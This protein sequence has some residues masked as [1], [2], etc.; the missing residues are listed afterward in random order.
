MATGTST[1]DGLGMGLQGEYE[2][3]QQVS[4]T[5][6]F[7]ITGAA[8]DGAGTLLTIQ[9]S[10]KAPAVNGFRIFDYGRTR[11]IRTDDAA[12]GGAFKNALDVKYDLN[13]AAGASQ[14]Y[15]A[16]FILDTAGG[17]W[18]GGRFSVI[19]L[20]SYGDSGVS[21]GNAASWIHLNDLGTTEVKTFLHVLG[22][23]IDTGIMESITDASTTHGLVMYWQNTKYYI[24]VSSSS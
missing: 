21:A 10:A 9:N 2:L 16:T 18:S 17:T 24:L 20:Q 23:T 7:T 5:D 3:T 1:Y 6:C 14:I 8:T 11:L 22:S 4:A 13:V 15:A 19:Q 12:H